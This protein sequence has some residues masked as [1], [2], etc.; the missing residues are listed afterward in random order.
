[1]VK[2]FSG[3]EAAEP[4]RQAEAKTVLT[5]WGVGA[6]ERGP[7]VGPEGSEIPWC[8]RLQPHLRQGKNTSSPFALGLGLVG[9]LSWWNV[10]SV[11]YF[12]GKTFFT[13]FYVKPCEKN[14]Q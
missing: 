3:G 10:R 9:F 12:V 6:G 7:R 2:V 1:M 5:F 11:S 4:G 14:K 13:I 8:T